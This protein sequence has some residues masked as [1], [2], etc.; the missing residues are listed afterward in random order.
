MNIYTS[1]YRRN[2]IKY[3][4]QY[5]PEW[6]IPNGFHVHHIKPR[7][8][9]GSDHPKNLI[10]L[11]PDDHLTIHKL[12]GDKIN[13]N[14]ILIGGPRAHSDETKQKISKA[15]RNPTK[16]TR[17]RKSRAKAKENNPNWGIPASE[18]QRKKVS[19]A[20]KGRLKS[21]ET[22]KRMSISGKN[23][24]KV[25]CPYCNKTGHPGPMAR[26]HFNNCKLK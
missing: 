15:N 10:A 1:N 6:E 3:W 8:E 11:H 4:R 20:L 25:Q 7:I 16:E 24:R 22:K 12:R 17:L 26:Y 9:G 14:F 21:E 18:E 2:L 19:K 5:Y 23:K 13:D